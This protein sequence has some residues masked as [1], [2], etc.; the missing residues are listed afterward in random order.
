VTM[1]LPAA[2][3]HETLAWI[4]ANAPPQSTI[5]FD[6]TYQRLIEMGAKIDIDK[7]PEKIK[8]G[9]LR[10]RSL[11]ANE[12]WIFGLPDSEDEFLRNL[13]WQLRKTMGMN[14]SEAVEKYLTR[15]DG[16]VF[17]FYPATG[18]QGYAILEAGI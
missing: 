18:Q 11:T 2:A 4:R 12:P 15:K 5:V 6:Y 17:G 14:S 9:L 7:L 3:V 16:T 13:G 10:F 1:Y 8:E